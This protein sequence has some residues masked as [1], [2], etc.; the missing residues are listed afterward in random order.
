MQIWLDLF[1]GRYTFLAILVATYLF[2]NRVMIETI[3]LIILLSHHVDVK[4]LIN[5]YT[6][7][8]QSVLSD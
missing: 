1:L 6:N 5:P 8:G 7:Q 2:K 3:L 4:V